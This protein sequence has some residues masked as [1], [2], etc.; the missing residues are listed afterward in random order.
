M[1]Y[2]LL[3][4]DSGLFVLMLFLSIFI[5]IIIY[6]AF[7]LIFAFSRHKKIT[8]KKYN[9][10]C[11]SINF[12]IMFLFHLFFGET[13]ASAAPYFLWTTIFSIVGSKTLQRKNLVDNTP[14]K[15]KTKIVLPEVKDNIS[16]NNNKVLFCR[17]CGQELQKESN[18]C[19]KCGT[20]IIK[21]IENGF[22][23][24]MPVAFCKNCGANITE[25]VAFCHICGKKFD[26]TTS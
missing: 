20:E 17:K 1:N 23:V 26:K 6:S 9:I 22:Q 4:E 7:P 18:F 11:F 13:N 10:L 3:E 8:T 25:D 12:A 15:A 14:K 5:T 21:N 16:E 24:S 2:E 19:N